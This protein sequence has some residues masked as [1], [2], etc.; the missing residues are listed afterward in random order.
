[1]PTEDHLRAYGSE[2]AALQ[3]VITA[4]P[5]LNVPLHPHLPYLYGH[6]I[7]AVRHEMARTVEDAL[8][9]RT[10]SL[11]LDARA[12]IDSASRVADVMAC[13]LGKDI[14]WKADQTDRFIAMAKGYLP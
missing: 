6:I 9:R 10:R 7:W 5:E 1:M 11:L 14:T 4:A 8:A 3:D 12:S 13:E 2:A